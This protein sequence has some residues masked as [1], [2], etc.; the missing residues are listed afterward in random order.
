MPK[1]LTLDAFAQQLRPQRSIKL[2]TDPLSELA[3]CFGES[4]EERIGP[5]ER[6]PIVAQSGVFARD[7]DRF[8]AGFERPRFHMRELSRMGF[9]ERLGVVFQGARLGAL[10]GWLL[11]AGL[12]VA[13]LVGW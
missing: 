10:T 6:A 11:A 3:D 9:V 12:L 5:T 1:E 2:P 4:R 7:G 13:R 8:F